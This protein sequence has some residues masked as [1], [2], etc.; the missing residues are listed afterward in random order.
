LWTKEITI[1]LLEQVSGKREREKQTDK[2][3]SG[4]GMNEEW[5]KERKNG[6]NE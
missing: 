2:Q 4:G 6:V 5:K 3:T 1:I